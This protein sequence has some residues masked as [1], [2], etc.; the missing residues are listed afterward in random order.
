M[1]YKKNYARKRTYKKKPYSGAAAWGQ[2]GKSV[3]VT[4]Y[5]A[6][7]LATKLARFVNTENKYYISNFA[8]EVI[9]NT[10]TIYNLCAPPQGITDTSRTGDSIKL[11]SVSGRLY[12]QSSAATGSLVRMIIFRGKQENG[13]T[14]TVG[15][16]IDTSLAADYLAPKPW[17]DRFRTKILYDQLLNMSTT[18]SRDLVRNIDIKLYG[19]LQFQEASATGVEDGGLYLMLI[20]NLAATNPTAN[21]HLRTTYV[22]N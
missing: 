1:A 21:W 3:G 11:M 14:P 22:D 12:F 9:T 18:G 20:G 5:K 13:T 4:A 15:S 17:D 2:T 7:S 8:A 16:V 6:Y 19:H 10:G